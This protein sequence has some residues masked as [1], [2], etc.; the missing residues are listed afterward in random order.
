MFARTTF[1]GVGSEA[2]DGVGEGVIY[3]ELPSKPLGPEDWWNIK[4]SFDRTPNKKCSVIFSEHKLHYKI[5]SLQL[6]MQS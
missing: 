4:E 2:R 1:K 3:I 5:M 6:R